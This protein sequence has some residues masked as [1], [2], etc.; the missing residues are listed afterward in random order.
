MQAI[1]DLNSPDAHE[2]LKVLRLSRLLERLIGLHLT[3]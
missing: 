2:A 1:V 3:V